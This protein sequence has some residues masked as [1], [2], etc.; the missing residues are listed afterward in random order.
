MQ[1]G[2]AVDPEGAD[3]AVKQVSIDVERVSLWPSES[4]LS[5]AAVSAS[6][7]RDF[8]RTLQ[9]EPGLESANTPRV[10]V[11]HPSTAI[12]RA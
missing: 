5:I 4:R 11:S 1:S 7:M 3:V 12:H 8:L 6:S 10:S 9:T 2:V